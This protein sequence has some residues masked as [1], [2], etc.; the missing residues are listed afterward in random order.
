MESR[1]MKLPSFFEVDGLAEAA[2]ESLL[3]LFLSLENLR[4]LTTQ[5]FDVLV[6]L[7]NL[8]FAIFSCEFFTAI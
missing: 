1:G 4:L 3:Q 6:K 8:F 7:C 2:I 5:R